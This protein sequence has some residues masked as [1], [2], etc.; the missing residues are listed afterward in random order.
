MALSDRIRVHP[1]AGRV[2]VVEEV[3]QE[4]VLEEAQAGAVRQVD[5]ELVG[6]DEAVPPDVPEEDERAETLLDCTERRRRAGRADLGAQPGKRN[7]VPAEAARRPFGEV[8]PGEGEAGRPYD[9]E[10]VRRA[11]EPERRGEIAVAESL[12]ERLQLGD[13]SAAQ[14]GLREGWAEL[15]RVEELER[16]GAELRRDPRRV[17]EVREPCVHECLPGRV[18]HGGRGPGG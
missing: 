9:D 13:A 17:A 3:H 1:D 15:Q 8:Q 7:R 4:L 18:V 2:R 16:H 5:A 11:D 14:D 10:R 6:I 12:D